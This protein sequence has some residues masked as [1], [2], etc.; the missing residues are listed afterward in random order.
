MSD[1]GF[2]FE[3]PDSKSIF[4]DDTELKIIRNLLKDHIKSNRQLEEK[5]LS[6]TS[7]N[8]ILENK[9]EELNARLGLMN[10]ETTSK[11]I[12]LGSSEFDISLEHE[13]LKARISSSVLKS[14]VT[15]LENEITFLKK[16][17]KEVESCLYVSSY[18]PVKVLPE[19]SIDIVSNGELNS[20]DSACISN[21]ITDNELTEL[22]KRLEAAELFVLSLIRKNSTMNWKKR[23]KDLKFLLMT[24]SHTINFQSQ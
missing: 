21:K 4:N 1:L 10:K 12:E 9:C 8:V 14:I 18:K 3:N 19:I 15:P 24:V 23:I 6:L 22:K 7:C 2:Q 13:M 11:N 20:I 17:L 5:N 16:R